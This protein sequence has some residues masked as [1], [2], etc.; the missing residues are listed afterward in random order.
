MVTYP[1]EH[2]KEARE[3]PLAFLPL[4]MGKVRLGE[5]L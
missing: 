5:E 4:R 3:M 1:F 2:L